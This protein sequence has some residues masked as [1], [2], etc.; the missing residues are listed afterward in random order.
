MKLFGLGVNC[1]L[2]VAGHVKVG[3]NVY[4]YMP[5]KKKIAENE[6]ANKIKI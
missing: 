4:L 1:D 6:E 3:D 5:K 2:Y